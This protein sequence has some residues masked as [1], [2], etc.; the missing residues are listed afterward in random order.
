[1][2]LTELLLTFLYLQPDSNWVSAPATVDA[3]ASR[4]DDTEAYLE[5][6]IMELKICRLPL[7]SYEDPN[8]YFEVYYT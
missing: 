5:K 2:S 8:I 4:Y 1:M 3:K 6:K 7:S